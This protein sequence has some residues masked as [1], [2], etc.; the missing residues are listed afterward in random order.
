VKSIAR[1]VSILVVLALLASISGVMPVAAVTG[2][3]TL[4][5]AEGGALI[6]T[7]A[8]VLTVT[9]NDAD[10]NTGVL[11][12]GERLDLDGNTNKIQATG[13][14]P[15]GTQLVFVQKFPILD[16]PDDDSI[17]NR[18]DVTVSTTPEFLESL[19]VVGVDSV[20]GLVTL[21]NTSLTTIPARTRFYLTYT[22]ADVQAT[23]INID[24]TSIGASFDLTLQ[25]TG[26]DTGVFTATVQTAT[27]TG[28]TA[29]QYDRTK[30]AS[31]T[32]TVLRGTIIR[33]F[34]IGVDV[35]GD[36]TTGD[37]TTTE[38][39]AIDRRLFHPGTTTEAL[40]VNAFGDSMN[41]DIAEGID[42]AASDGVATTNI[43]PS[44]TFTEVP[45]GLDLNGNGV[46]KETGLTTILDFAFTV[47]EKL[48]R[49]DGNGDGVTD[50]DVGDILGVDL[51]GDGFTTTTLATGI[52]VSKLP[53]SLIRPTIV[54]GVGAI[55]TG[56][57]VDADPA[58]T[59]VGTASV[60]TTD[61]VITVVE[62][63]D[64]SS[65]QT[66]DTLLIA[67]VTDFDS[68]VIAAS[69]RFNIISPA[70]VTAP[71]ANVRTTAISGGFRAD[72]RLVGVLAGAVTDIVWQVT[73]SDEGGNLGRSDSDA[74][75]AAPDTHAL[76]VDL[77]PPV[78]ADPIGAITGQH[79]DDD[80]A[81]V[82]A[83]TSADRNKIRVIFDEDIEAASVGMTDLTV[84]GVNPLAVETSASAPNSVVLT[85][86]TLSGNAKPDIALTGVI[87]DTAGNSVSTLPA[88]KARDG[89]APTLTVIVSPTLDT[90]EVDIE[91]A[92]DEPIAVPTIQVNGVTL[93]PATLVTTELYTRTFD[94]TDEPNVYSVEVVISDTT[95]NTSTAG[96]LPHDAAEAIL[97]EI[98]DVLPAPTTIPAD[99]GE[100]FVGSPVF[101]E[102][103]WTS[104]GTEYGLDGA[105]GAL[106]TTSDNVVVDLDT[107]NVVTLTS[108]TLNGVDV[109]DQ[110]RVEGDAT[111]LL[112]AGLLAEGAYIL[113]FN[114]E[115]EAGNVLADDLTV[116]FTVADRPVFSIPMTTGWNLIS[117]PGA[118]LAG[119]RGVNDVIPLGHPIDTVTT[120]DPTQPQKWLIAQR[121][122][123]GTFET[124][125]IS[126]IEL[127]LAYWVRTSGFEPLDV[128]VP[129]ARGGTN[130]VLPT[131][132]LVAGWNLLPVID[133]TGDKAAGDSIS[134]DY[135][136]GLDIQR[137]YEYRPTL[138]R[139]EEVAD[140]NDLE[141]GKGYW[142][143]V[144]SA[145]TVVP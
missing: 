51:D 21:Q 75:T 141:V 145:G 13:L 50:N 37:D 58:G 39:F 94:P 123:D 3:V 89:I 29:D 137:I 87:T 104:E 98:D 109:S 34:D 117:L 144:D 53:N 106:A 84:D 64:G 68:G 86:S 118:P 121:L 23:S 93:A 103:D 52:D 125:E 91:V 72:V 24:S 126:E 120:Y 20:N 107:H 7:P 35:N 131:F 100:V 30:A 62:P 41:L 136:A 47:N 138:D 27:T 80:G 115:D 31:S 46:L 59:R 99:E 11:Q 43:F 18:S 38:T 78:F 122:E 134:K 81:V 1:V 9:V 135:L 111:F 114:G 12:V 129:G 16:G 4:Q 36:G 102:I 130:Q 132:R 108:I 73:A 19:R 48:A 63:A 17:L 71:A 116:D 142:V 70:V 76:R 42:G 32:D 127:G 119:K 69:I 33:E 14:D 5:N 101:V 28:T 6:T 2:T 112:A 26:P 45:S 54:A 67:D 90:T 40:L 10:L 8:G 57:Y 140:D 74:A 95:G 96:V 79:F 25:E 61:P 77:V 110:I 105:G 128:T 44:T 85:V 55:I 60:E 124:D 22:A 49:I 143:W 97:F 92:A 139:F 113:V 133:V 56:S 88:V 82:T 83:A 15:N 65:T 66:R